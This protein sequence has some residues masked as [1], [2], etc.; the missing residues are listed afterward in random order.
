M[1]VDVGVG[2]GDDVGGRKQ[3]TT[4]RP[5]S[6]RSMGANYALI[7]SLEFLGSNPTVVSAFSGPFFQHEPV[8][9]AVT[10][11]REQNKLALT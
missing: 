5:Q 7:A 2:V 1:V 4:A 8:G 9:G 11:R 10:T 3:A 6:C